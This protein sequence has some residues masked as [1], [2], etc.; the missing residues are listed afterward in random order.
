MM[1]AGFQGAVDLPLN[2]TMGHAAWSLETIYS[3]SKVADVAALLKDGSVPIGDNG[4][5]GWTG[6]IEISCGDSAVFDAIESDIENFVHFLTGGSVAVCSGPSAI[7]GS[8]VKSV[9]AVKAVVKAV[10]NTD[11]FRRKSLA[12]KN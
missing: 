8:E 3:T 4:G 2:C 11:M 12:T 7:G 10:Y 9:P 1:R 6:I 5:N